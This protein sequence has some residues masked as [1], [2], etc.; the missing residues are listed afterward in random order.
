M[1][2]FLDPFEDDVLLL[3]SDGLRGVLFLLHH[4]LLSLMIDEL[5]QSEVLYVADR[6]QLLDLEQFVVSL[7]GQE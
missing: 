7:P 4:V 2:G 6:V 3:L 5:V 1:L